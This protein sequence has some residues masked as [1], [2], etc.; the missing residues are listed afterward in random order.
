MSAELFQEFERLNKT[1]KYLIS[2]KFPSQ[3]EALK[4]P[5]KD[6]YEDPGSSEQILKS[7]DISKLPRR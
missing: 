6:E 5:L 7:G 4:N 1:A 3:V 2:K